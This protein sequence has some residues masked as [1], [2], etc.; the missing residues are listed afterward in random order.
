[1]MNY[2]LPGGDKEKSATLPQRNLGPGNHTPSFKNNLVVDLDFIQYRKADAEKSQDIVRLQNYVNYQ[3]V[4]LAQNLDDMAQDI[5]HTKSHMNGL[6]AKI[7]NLEHNQETLKSQ[8][9]QILDKLD[10]IQTAIHSLN[11][12]Y[13]KE[14]EP[15]SPIRY[16]KLEKQASFKWFGAPSTSTSTGEQ[17]H[18]TLKQLA[19][20]LGNPILARIAQVVLIASEKLDLVKSQFSSLEEEIKSKHQEAIPLVSFIKGIDEAES[21]QTNAPRSTDDDAGGN[22]FQ[23]AWE[24][25]CNE[26]YGSS[27]KVPFDSAN[28]N[29]HASFSRENIDPAPVPNLNYRSHNEMIIFQKWQAWAKTQKVIFRNR[30]YWNELALRLTWGFTRNLGLWWDR[31]NETDKLRIM[32]HDNPIE[33]L[34]KAVVHEFY[35]SPR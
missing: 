1:M 19:T 16:A 34:I 22:P 27:K 9:V 31:V 15:S 12:S 13:D 32:N 30:V 24:K 26:K 10:T 3:S 5:L 6:D 35:S 20:E 8:L 28:S 21:S 4:C 17:K 29:E 33:E 7:D 14:K 18:L 11:D 2:P 25:W 23:S